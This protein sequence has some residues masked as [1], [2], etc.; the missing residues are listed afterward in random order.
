MQNAEQDPEH[1]YK[2]GDVYEALDKV[3]DLELALARLRRLG[4]LNARALT[5]SKRDLED[6]RKRV[7][8]PMRR[9]GLSRLLPGRRDGPDWS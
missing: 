8:R 7:E 1:Y 9:R 2:Y 5:A 6:I 4:L 3:Q